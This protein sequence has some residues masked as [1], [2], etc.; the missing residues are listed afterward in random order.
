MERGR[1]TILSLVAM[2]RITPREAER[3]LAAWNAGREE[4]W[5]IGACA[6]WGVLELLPGASRVAHWLLPAGWPG[7]HHAL[8]AIT[9][10]WGGVL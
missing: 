8:A 1:L 7:V 3:L 9:C 10:W 5:V 6:V 4:L 2:G